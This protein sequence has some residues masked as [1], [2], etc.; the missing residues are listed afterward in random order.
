M[1]DE[2]LLRRTIA[3]HPAEDVPQLMLADLKQE[4]GDDFGAWALRTNVEINRGLRAVCAAFCGAIQK[5]AD[6]HYGG[7]YAA[8][9]TALSEFSNRRS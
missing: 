4:R 8:A 6:E 9:V 2:D 5:V 3:D 1:T 7:N